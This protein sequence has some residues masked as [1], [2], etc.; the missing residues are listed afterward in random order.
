MHFA[1]K[2]NCYFMEMV[3]YQEEREMEEWVGEGG[4]VRR[5][6]GEGDRRELVG[7]H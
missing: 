5:R 6:E 3:L 2:S 4:G 7:Q 1:L